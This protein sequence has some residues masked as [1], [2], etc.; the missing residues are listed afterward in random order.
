MKSQHPDLTNI[1]TTYMLKQY[2]VNTLLFFIFKTMKTI[3]RSLDDAFC[4]FYPRLCLACE[5]KH[6]PPNQIICTSC[7]YQLPRTDFHLFIENEF[8]KKFWGRINI[9][10]AASLFYFYKKSKTQHLIHNLKYKGKK[11]VGVALG[12]MLGRTL[13]DSSP[14]QDID[15]IV[16]IPL[17]L[18]REIQ[19][20]YNQSAVFAQGLSEVMNIPWSSDVLLRTSYTQSQTKKSRL[21]RFE[22]VIQAFE[23]RKPQLIENYHILLVDDVL[24]TGA[25][26]EAGAIKLLEVKGVKVSMATIAFAK[27]D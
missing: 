2:F 3:I 20:G 5:L 16:P 19:R 21:E 1:V 11:D 26:L 18:K 13:K 6:L 23:I 14:Y 7:E 22:N 4:L 9:H 15:L 25:T 10:T 27:N 24:T 12:K 8:T 17:H